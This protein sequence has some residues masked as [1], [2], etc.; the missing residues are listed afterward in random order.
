VGLDGL[1]AVASTAVFAEIPT[2]P[3][4]FQQATDRLYRTGQAG[5]VNIYLLVV[6]GTIAVRLRN[7][8]VKKDRDANDVLRDKR[9]LLGELM[10]ES[11][12]QGELK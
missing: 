3:G 8:L 1:Q 12:I 10:G 6:R 2:V 9:T 11:G 4:L 5:T 7:N